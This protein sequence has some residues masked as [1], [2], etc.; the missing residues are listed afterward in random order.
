MRLLREQL[1]HT[2]LYLSH[3]PLQP[4][5]LGVLLHLHATVSVQLFQGAQF[6]CF[7]SALLVQKHKKSDEEPYHQLGDEALEALELA[8]L[9]LRSVSICTFY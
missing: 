9:L 7:T 5:H 3:R 8:L 1:L 6:S 2:R 4:R